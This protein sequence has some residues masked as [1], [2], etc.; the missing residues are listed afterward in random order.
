MKK[1]FRRLVCIFLVL[2]L[3]PLGGCSNDETAD[4]STLNDVNNSINGGYVVETPDG[5]YFLSDAEGSNIL[6]KIEDEKLEPAVTLR[7]DYSFSRPCMN[8]YDGKII[9]YLCNP[10]N[11]WTYPGV[12]LS[13]DPQS[14][15]QEILVEAP[16]WQIYITG[17]QMFY[18]SG[19]ASDV[20]PNYSNSPVLRVY[21][22][23]TGEDKEILEAVCP[24]IHFYFFP[25]N[26]RI[27]FAYSGSEVETMYDTKVRSAF[28]LD[29]NA[30]ENDPI[31]EAL[32]D[33]LVYSVQVG[34]DAVYF[35]GHPAS[36]GWR[37]YSR[38]YRLSLDDLSITTL[39]D[40]NQYQVE[41][42]C[43]VDD[44]L[45]IDTYGGEL[46]QMTTDGEDQHIYTKRPELLVYGNYETN[47]LQVTSNNVYLYKW[48][49]PEANRN[50]YK[51]CLYW[52]S[53]DDLGLIYEE[54]VTY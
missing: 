40:K 19:V 8:Y 18:L 29:G 48:G 44:Y 31:V 54:V 25:L 14:G 42:F 27:Y 43:L 15:D 37:S 47:S 52:V 24:D 45:L 38:I 28:D 26:D 53:L 6:Y 17:D 36:E 50:S 20:N 16:V 10:T 32:S 1:R 23:K 41:T 33:Y 3:L 4:T 34:S 2:M 11:S 39:Y 49:T 9:L 22:L 51:T 5:N 35:K 12:I 46:V 13:V 30:V 7:D 21:D